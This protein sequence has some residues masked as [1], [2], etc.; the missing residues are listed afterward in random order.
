M[1]LASRPEILPRIEPPKFEHLVADVLKDRW[2]PCDVKLVGGTGDGGID[3]ILIM[4]ESEE[5]LV[6]VKRIDSRSA[7]WECFHNGYEPN[8][9]EEVNSDIWFRGCGLKQ[10]E[11]LEDSLYFPRAGMVASLLWL[12]NF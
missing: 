10:T 7:A 3:V 11:L 5:Y 4:G 2:A 6:Q 9:M 8:G 1:E 12:P